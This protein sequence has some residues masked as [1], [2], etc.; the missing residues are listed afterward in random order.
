MAQLSVPVANSIQASN[1][2]IFG[3]MLE[4]DY[5][6]R[7]KFELRTDHSGRDVVV[8]PSQ[9]PREQANQLEA[10]GVLLSNRHDGSIMS[11]F[12]FSSLS[13]FKPIKI[14]WGSEACENQIKEHMWAYY[15]DPE[16]PER[17]NV[18]NEPLPG[19]V[20]Y[21][22]NQLCGDTQ[23]VIGIAGGCTAMLR[24][25]SHMQYLNAELTDITMVDNS[26]HAL[27]NAAM[28]IGAH[29]SFPKLAAYFV[30]NPEREVAAERLDD[31]GYVACR[32]LG[33][34][35]EYWTAVAAV[36]KNIFR[37]GTE[38]KMECCDIIEYIRN[39]E[40]EKPRKAFIYL[41]NVL[42]LPSLEFWHATQNYL[43]IEASQHLLNAIAKKDSFA[44]GSMVLTY[45][46]RSSPIDNPILLQKKDGILVPIDLS[47]S[48]TE[49]KIKFVRDF[50]YP[51]N[52]EEL[53]S[54]YGGLYMLFANDQ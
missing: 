47:A 24:L 33:G 12:R 19:E 54:K 32:M 6:R 4:E 15:A 25:V 18:S 46:D 49:S 43:S 34:P 21:N 17:Y 35:E 44:D 9:I 42:A 48:T 40:Y 50:S 51:G 13:E 28:H 45:F 14:K 22:F 2:A 26:F 11:A 1:K 29:N 7:S 23:S 30:R 20:F 3:K 52:M 31:Y 16:W 53:I 38:I 5:A 39:V 10:M 36:R 27:A 41:S 37:P 8:P